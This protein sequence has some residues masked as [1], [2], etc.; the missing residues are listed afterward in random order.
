[1]LWQKVL[2]F[3]VPCSFIELLQTECFKGNF[4]RDDRT[5]NSTLKSPHVDVTFLEQEAYF[6]TSLVSMA[7]HNTFTFLERLL[8]HSAF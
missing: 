3:L 4:P 8:N 6:M 1:M 2:P 7:V 5:S